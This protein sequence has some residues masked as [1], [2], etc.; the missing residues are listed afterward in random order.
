MFRYEKKDK[1][2][3]SEEEEIRMTERHHEVAKH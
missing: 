1:E 2:K 3:G